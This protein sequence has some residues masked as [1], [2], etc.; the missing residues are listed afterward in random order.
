MDAALVLP[1]ALTIG[2]LEPLRQQ[3]LGRLG[4]HHGLRLDGRGVGAIDT[5]GLQL[6]AVLCRDAADRGMTVQWCG[7]S[8][9]LH[10]G[11]ALLGLTAVLG[12]EPG[13]PAD[14]PQT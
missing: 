6:L 2:E 10:G 11:A 4:S 9:E 13:V 1:A 12:L 8:P 14:V 5:A 7:V 3:L